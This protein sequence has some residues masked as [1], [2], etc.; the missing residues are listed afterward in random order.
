MA[1]LKEVRNRIASVKSTKQITSAMKMVAASK[2]RKAQ[3]AI[4]TMRPYA[5][6]LQ[7]IMQN[8]STSMSDSNE[9]VFTKQRELKK[10]LL[11]V[12]TSNRGLCG[13]FNIN[14]V[15]Q[16]AHLLNTELAWQHRQNNVDLLCVG[17]KGADLLKSKGFSLMEV[18]TEIFNELSFSNVTPLAVKLMVD[19]SAGTYDR[20][21]I[22]YNRFKNAA[23]QVLETEQF[24]PIVE[25]KPENIKG[26]HRSQPNYI[27]EPDKEEIL[28]A[29]IPKTLQIQF[30]KV[31]LD[32]FAAE[33]GA[34]MTSMHQATENATELLKDLNLSYNK[35]RQ[36]SITNEILE[37]V[38]GA[39]A[40]RG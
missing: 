3:N 38:S 14:V 18:N 31:L 17:K 16:A 30:Y 28:M 4:L 13:A 32:S 22:I 25:T 5:S 19:Y 21:T 40:L 24:L 29:L 8:L 23:V 39:E 27:F 11:V 36:A 1:N 10:V 7:E 12:V 2:L 15:K 33:H 34:R 9:S 6:K 35:A 20:I 26:S 37:I